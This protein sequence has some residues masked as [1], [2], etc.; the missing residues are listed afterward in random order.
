M[1]TDDHVVIGRDLGPHFELFIKEGERDITV[2]LR[3]AQA[4]LL[5]EQLW[6]YIRRTLH[7][8]QAGK[9]DD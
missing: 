8:A 4:V 7:G 2:R 6:L 3:D 1:T 9:A 5:Y